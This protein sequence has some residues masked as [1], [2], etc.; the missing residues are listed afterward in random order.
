[1]AGFFLR[2]KNGDVTLVKR[3]DSMRNTSST[4][5]WSREDIHLSSRDEGKKS[6]A[7]YAGRFTPDE[8]D[9][10]SNEP[11]IRPV[12]PYATKNKK[13]KA[14]EEK[15]KGE[16]KKRYEAAVP[17]WLTLPRSYASRTRVQS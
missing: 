13:K 8:R 14:G 2:C 3:P 10:R 5:E 9:R 16:R 7:N 6:L 12:F 15:E 17:R 11:H 4:S 1:M